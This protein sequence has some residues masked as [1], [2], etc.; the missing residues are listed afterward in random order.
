MSAISHRSIR[1]GPDWLEVSIYN[2]HGSIDRDLVLSTWYISTMHQ[3]N[4]SIRFNRQFELRNW[5]LRKIERGYERVKCFQELAWGEC[6]CVC[7][8]KKVRKKSKQRRFNQS[9]E[10][11]IN[12]KA[13]ACKKHLS[14]YIYSTMTTDIST[15]VLTTINY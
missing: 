8:K 7:V 10:I 11:P 12:Y 14:R 4:H 6:V 5:Y 13:H 9:M 3:L 1:S 2:T 15:I